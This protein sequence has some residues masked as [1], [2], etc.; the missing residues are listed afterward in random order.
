VA[1]PDGEEIDVHRGYNGAA[2]AWSWIQTQ[3][4]VA[5]TRIDSDP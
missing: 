2:S 4:K 5:E 1:L 3:A